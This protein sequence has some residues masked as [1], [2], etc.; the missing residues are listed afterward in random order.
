MKL[1]TPF[2]SRNTAAVM[3]LILRTVRIGKMGA[4]LL[5]MIVWSGSIAK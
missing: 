4:W 2:T 5:R 1:N 3:R